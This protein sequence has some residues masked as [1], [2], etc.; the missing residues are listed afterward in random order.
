MWSFHLCSSWPW[1]CSLSRQLWS[2]DSDNSL[3]KPTG[4]KLF[5]AIYP[6][7]PGWAGIAP[8]PSWGIRRKVPVWHPYGSIS[9]SAPPSLCP[10]CY[11][12]TSETEVKGLERM[13]RRE[14]PNSERWR[15]AEVHPSRH[16]H[17][18]LQTDSLMGLGGW[19]MGFSKSSGTPEASISHFS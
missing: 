13:G 19:N 12:N 1:L 14:N 7:S 4:W 8:G 18:L 2:L 11:R 17:R 16:F 10:F 3:G 15:S 9:Y 6:K 5:L